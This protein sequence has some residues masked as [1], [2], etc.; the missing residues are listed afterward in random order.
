MTETPKSIPPENIFGTAKKIHLELDKLNPVDHA[1]IVN[2][3][4]TMLQHREMARK[5]EQAEAQEKARQDAMEA[6]E[7]AH[8]AQ[9]AK[10]AEKTAKDAGLI[11]VS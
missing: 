9:Q 10:L 5:F 7:R 11:L 3:I 4:G 1:A 8:A 6:A 2:M